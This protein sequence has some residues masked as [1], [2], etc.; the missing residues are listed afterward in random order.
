MMSKIKCSPLYLFSI[1]LLLLNACTTDKVDPTTD[2]N[3][4]LSDGFGIQGVSIKVKN[5]DQA[6][7]YFTDTLGFSLPPSEW[8][9]KGLFDSTEMASYYFADFS[10]F[11]LIA[12]TDS[13]SKMG[14]QA[15]IMQQNK[16]AGLY[17]FSTSSVDSTSNWLQAQGFKTDTI[18]AGRSAKE[19]GKGWDWDNGGPQ[20]QSLSFANTMIGNALPSF[21]Q[22]MDL[23]T[24]KSKMNGN[25]WHGE[26]IIRKIPMVS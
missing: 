19:I 7:N 18:R 17:A 24:K 10:T 1:L 21:L 20:W 12:T 6:R 26:D 2:T 23:P 3:R 13:I 8:Y 22:Y 14:K 25:L 15:S 16:S 4:L 9:E 11:D 5:L